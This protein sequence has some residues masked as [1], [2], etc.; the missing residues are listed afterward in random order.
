MPYKQVQFIAHCLYT[1][2][3]VNSY[4]VTQDTQ[5]YRGLT[6]SQTD[7]D[8]RVQ[9]VW[10]VIN[11]A[12]DKNKEH[13]RNGDILK[14]YMMPEFSFRG[15]DG[16]YDPKYITGERPGLISQL[17]NLVRE[18]KWKDWI[19]IFGTIITAFSPEEDAPQVA[20]EE[21]HYI[22]DTRK[23]EVYNFSLVQIG[24]F[25]DNHPSNY[26]HIVQKR[27]LAKIDFIT[28]QNKQ[29]KTAGLTL[30]RVFSTQPK[31]SEG[32][33]NAF[34]VNING[35]SIN[36]GLEICADHGNQRLRKANKK[37][38]IQ[39]IPS[40][41][42]YLNISAV[43]ATQ[44]VFLCDGLY[45][46]EGNKNNVV[47]NL[48][49]VKFGQSTD[50]EEVLG[51]VNPETGNFQYRSYSQVVKTETQTKVTG[52]LNS[53][54]QQFEIQ[55]LPPVIINDLYSAGPGKI[56]V[57]PP[58]PLSASVPPS[59]S[60]PIAIAQSIFPAS[61]FVQALSNE[62]VLLNGMRVIFDQPVGVYPVTL[63]SKTEGRNGK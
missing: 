3:A 9:F 59:S 58:Q 2:P 33:G 11:Q 17:Q 5:E 1:G 18:P 62:P 52:I 43:A 6:N 7:I 49:T 25:G 61:S 12:Y 41:G 40:A 10:Q 27:D 45:N 21:R 57:Y 13:S 42:Q 28:K 23:K 54:V 50:G 35:S 24:G 37:V 46:N 26:A 48:V 32:S 15:R 14:I 19:F 22:N 63:E 55:V 56:H 36:F 51:P 4:L 47:N 53:Q 8:K 29:L 38:D 16:A 44:Y 31:S 60:K 30:E 39:L 20:K 34:T